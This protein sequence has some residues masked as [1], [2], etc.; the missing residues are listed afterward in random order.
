[1]TVGATSAIDARVSLLQKTLADLRHLIDQA[2]ELGEEK[3]PPEVPLSKQLKVGRSTL[4]EALALLEAEGVIERGRGR[5]TRIRRVGAVWGP[6]SVAYPVHMI[7]ALSEFLTASGIDYTVRELRVQQEPISEKV[8]A[9]LPDV[10]AAEVFR[11]SRLFEVEGRRAAFL[12]HFL[13]TVVEGRTLNI[14]SLREGATTFLED[15]EGFTLTS[16]E[17]T[18]TAESADAERAQQLGV[19]VGQP[20]LVMYAKFFAERS[21]AIALGCLVF[22]PDVLSMS[23]HAVGHVVPSH[24]RDADD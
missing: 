5:G 21:G 22:R 11:V 3:L 15:I 24:V 7:L 14:S 4:R 10:S 23:V 18:I 13:P 17:N 8:R 16:V 6:A 19:E 1:M 12:E 20:L 2:H 9:A